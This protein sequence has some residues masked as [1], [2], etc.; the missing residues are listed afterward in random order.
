MKASPLFMAVIYLIM[1]VLFIF[2]AINNV[3]ET[4]WNLTTII[5]ASI[6]TLDIAVA[7]RLLATHFKMKKK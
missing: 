1:A 7:L 5:M 4:V 2:L 6:A 3:G